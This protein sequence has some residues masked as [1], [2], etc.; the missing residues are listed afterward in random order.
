MSI[1]RGSRA[2]FLESVILSVLGIGVYNCVLQFVVYPAFSRQLGAQ[3]FG[4]VL[5]LLSVQSIFAISAGAGVSYA[6]M[7]NVPRFTASNGDYNRMLLPGFA[8]TVAVCVGTLICFGSGTAVSFLLYPV[9]GVVTALRYYCAAAFRLEIN[10]RKNL[11]YYL[12]LSCGYLAG[13]ALFHVCGQWETALLCGEVLAAAYTAL[14]SPILR[15]PYLQK[16]A[17]FPA[18]RRSC[19]ALV[20]AQVF[21]YLTMHADRLLIGAVLDG[22]QVSIYYT[23]SLL[24]KAMAMLTEPIA[25]VAIGFLARTR[26]FGRLQY[27]LA[28]AGCAALGLAA[29]AVMIPVSPF[30]IGLLYPDIAPD[31]AP[32]YLAA[33][34][35]QIVYF[36]ANLLLVI[37]LRFMAEKYQT[38]LNASYGVC[39]FLLCTPA[40]RYGGLPLFCKAVLLLNLLRLAVT[41]LLGVYHA[42]KDVTTHAI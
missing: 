37:A 23:A 35:G 21:L 10:Y 2:H 29:F 34:G 12:L 30:L 24:G 16:S 28:A 27:L 40:L 13:L 5:T 22:T 14:R 31:A 3:G 6:R 11:V 7:A 1:R 18:V 9:L 33:N 32:Y 4:D 38:I 39:F 15:A 42:K 36:I 25:G 19:T 20:T 17:H 41:L 8:V 26:T